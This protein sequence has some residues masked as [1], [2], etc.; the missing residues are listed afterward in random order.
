MDMRSKVWV[1]GYLHACL[2]RLQVSFLPGAWMSL[3]SVVCCQVKVSA[4]GQS[5]VQR[6]PIK[7]GMLEAEIT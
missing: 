7:C 1:C 5:L 3:L 4:T 2:L 6:S